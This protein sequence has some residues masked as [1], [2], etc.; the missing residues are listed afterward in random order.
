[1]D[2]DTL[3][4]DIIPDS[5]LLETAS[6]PSSLQVFARVGGLSLLAEHLNVLYPDVT[7]VGVLGD[8][9]AYR[10]G[11]AGGGG[12]S[13]NAGTSTMMGADWVTVESPDD[14]YDVSKL[15]T[16]IV[17]KYRHYVHQY[18]FMSSLS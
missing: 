17:H 12:G 16:T 7:R 2:D 15:S 14:L 1:M 13:A 6:M 3:N 9:I 5:V 8:D 4:D 10:T 11:G 18:C